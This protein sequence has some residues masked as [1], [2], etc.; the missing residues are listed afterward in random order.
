MARHGRVT[1]ARHVTEDDI[2]PPA[3]AA[4]TAQPAVARAAPAEPPAAHVSQPWRRDNWPYA[5]T[6]ISPDQLEASTRP[7]TGRQP[8]SAGKAVLPTTQS[9]LRRGAEVLLDVGTGIACLLACLVM[10][11]LA[12]ATNVIIAVISTVLGTICRPFLM[13]CMCCAD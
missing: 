11:P 4:A 6:L 5:D 8:A 13:C 9:W 10:V 2:S 1:V 3:Y 7:S 12:L